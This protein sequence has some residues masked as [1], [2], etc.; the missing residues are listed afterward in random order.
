MK[1]LAET[2]S[3]PGTYSSSELVS[4]EDQRL[5]NTL[6]NAKTFSD[7]LP[8]SDTDYEVHNLTV[9]LNGGAQEMVVAGTR[10]CFSIAIPDFTRPI[11][12]GIRPNTPGLYEAVFDFKP[13]GLRNREV[14]QRVRAIIGCRV[15]VDQN[16]VSNNYGYV[17]LHSY[18]EQRDTKLYVSIPE[19]SI[20]QVRTRYDALNGESIDPLT[21]AEAVLTLAQSAQLTN[22]P[23]VVQN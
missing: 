22:T 6:R 3:A 18:V 13:A 21:N 12:A 16:T 10:N 14:M 23:A 1:A 7:S 4:I 5:L 2:G 15:P 9:M 19:V 11:V 8:W 20:K 17:E